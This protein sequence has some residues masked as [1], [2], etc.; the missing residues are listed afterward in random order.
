MKPKFHTILVMAVEQAINECVT[1]GYRRAHKHIENPT[2]ECY[3]VISVEEQCVM[4]QIYE[5]FTFEDE[6]Y[7]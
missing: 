6:T 4:A 7:V 1:R 3:N 2:E 5:Y